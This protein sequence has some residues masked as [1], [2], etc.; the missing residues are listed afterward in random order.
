MFTSPS[1]YLLD[2]VF[3][4]VAKG[5]DEYGKVIRKSYYIF[6]LYVGYQ[7]FYLIQ[8]LLFKCAVSSTLYIPR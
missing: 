8:T 6:K 5:T 3:G 2:C 7:G 1:E 4:L